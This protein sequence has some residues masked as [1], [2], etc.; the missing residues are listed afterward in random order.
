MGEKIESKRQERISEENFK[1]Q[2]HNSR[3]ISFKK[4]DILHIA[5]K[6]N[7][8]LSVDTMSGNNRV[9]KARCLPL[10]LIIY[11]IFFLLDIFLTLSYIGLRA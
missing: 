3:N 6:Y 8:L 11:Y 5:D 1:Q 2:I 10:S 4:I 9:Y 7:K